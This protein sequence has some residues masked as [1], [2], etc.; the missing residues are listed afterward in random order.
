MKMLK[1]LFL[2][3]LVIQTSQVYSLPIEGAHAP[4]ARERGGILDIS[5]VSAPEVRAP[6]VTSV[7]IVAEQAAH[8]TV[9]AT[10]V[11]GHS[12]V[13][14]SSSGIL[15]WWQSLVQS[16]QDIA[17]GISNYISGV[18]S[19][20]NMSNIKANL[21]AAQKLFDKADFNAAILSSDKAIKDNAL[22][23]LKS[24]ADAQL[25]VAN[26]SID[27]ALRDVGFANKRLWVAA[28]LGN[29]G[30]I[31]EALAN[32]KEVEARL[33]SKTSSAG[34]GAVILPQPATSASVVPSSAPVSGGTVALAPVVSGGD[35]G[36]EPSPV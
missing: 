30:E 14:Q 17:T 7:D 5:G 1:N 6:E 9:E 28:S 21:N 2:L 36:F 23:A 4:L 29:P 32:L 3:V 22:N 25:A 26:A 8:E 20:M 27:L 31:A 33:V 15:E 34:G 18:R 12:G 24:L 16:V 35:L 11:G 10:P 19:N 13:G